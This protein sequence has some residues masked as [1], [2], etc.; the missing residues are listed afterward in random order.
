MSADY[1]KPVYVPNKDKYQSNAD[2]YHQ[3]EKNDKP[4]QHPTDTD[5]T[6]TPQPK[7][8]KAG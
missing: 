4:R 2:K 5:H 3:A 1:Q 6:R 8:K 7:K